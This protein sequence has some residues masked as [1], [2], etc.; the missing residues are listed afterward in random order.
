MKELKCPNCGSVFKVD[1]ATYES[2]SNQVKNKAFREEVERRAE[3]IKAQMRSDREVEAVKSARDHERQLAERDARHAEAVASLERMITE[4]Q[5][6]V[7]NHEARLK[8]AVMEA[9]NEAGD[10]IRM[11]DEKITRLEHEAESRRNEATIREKNMREQHALELRQKDEAIEYY[12]E[13]KMRLS[14]KMIGE[15]LETHCHNEFMQARSNG[16]FPNAY[17]EKDN[18]AR[19][20][21][22]G[23][24]IFR[25]YDSDGREY[26]S[27]MFEMKNEA[28][29]TATRHK[30]TD[31]LEKLDRDRRAKE[32]E[33]AVLVT[34]LE[35]DNELYNGGLVNMSYL[36]PKMYVIRPQMFIPLISLISQ[37]SRKN[38]AE[39]QQMRRDLEVA[40][41][42]SV[43]VTNFERRRDQFA[44]TFGKL[45]DA[46]LKKQEDAL[47]GIDKVI[48][49]LERQLDNLR[50]V[51]S[52]FESSA[53]KLIKAN[54]SVEND[55][56]IKKLTRGNPTMKRKFEE[57]RNQRDE[58]SE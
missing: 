4:L 20:G 29:T 12:K 47:T 34:L 57:A 22:K 32:C 6:R 25:D 24:F 5:G 19:Q 36:Y 43:D 9:R 7:A 52:L 23:D 15:S 2:L 26:V 45:V 50:K 35:R 42:Q 30:N 28:D 48:D 41:S 27:I 54:E 31:F 14:T 56:T 1:S 16:M 33:Y 21:S 37:A 10:Q 38:L 3:E 58:T 18:D 8:M 55:F 49:S 46:H 44:A 17:F 40:R 39:L 13:M 53:G 51:K 11:R